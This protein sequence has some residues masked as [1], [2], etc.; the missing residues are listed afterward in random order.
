MKFQPIK[1]KRSTWPANFHE[2]CGEGTLYLPACRMEKMMVQHKYTG[3]AWQ[4]RRMWKTYRPGGKVVYKSLEGLNPVNEADFWHIMESNCRV[5]LPPPSS[6]GS[7]FHRL[8][9]LQWPKKSVIAPFREL[10][11]GAWS[12]ALT[13]GT[14]TEKMYHYDITSAYRW[15]ACEGLPLLKSGKRV[16]DLDAEQSIFLVRFDKENRP[17]WFASDVSMLTSEE[18]QVLGIRPTLLFGIQFRDWLGLSGV[19]A[20]IDKRFPW[21]Y[22]R[23]GRAFWGRWNG[24]TDVQQHGWKDGH[25]VRQLP[26]PLHNP[27]WSHYITSRVKLRLWDVVK[28]AGAVHVQVDAVLC[29]EPLPETG[30][31]GGWLLKR[32]YPK[33]LWVAGTGVWGSGDLIVKRMGMTE[34]E[35]EQWRVQRIS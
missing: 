35:A 7:I 11:C 30:Q 14:F 32:D 18:I 6:F 27:I 8:C 1:N 13:R 9:R 26:N 19:F 28:N 29:R 25:K 23:I 24:E 5:G 2:S 34:R 21:C 3:Q 22:K 31:V 15:S 33:G 17:P 12:N 4:F 20:E 10:S 16:F